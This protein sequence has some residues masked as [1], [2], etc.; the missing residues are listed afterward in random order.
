MNSMSIAVRISLAVAGLV[1]V[2]VAILLPVSLHKL[3][4]TIAE[5]EQRELYGHYHNFLA[6]VDQSADKAVSMARLVAGIPLVQETFARGDREGLK[7]LFAPGFATLK[8]ESG[9]R[10]FQFHVPPA[11]SFLRLHKLEK[12]GD[13]L[14]GFRHT[15]LQANE[16]KAPVQGLERGVAGLGIRGVVPVFHE[17]GHVGTV[18][19]GPGFDQTFVQAFKERFGVDVTV[20]TADKDTGA[21]ATLAS[22][23]NGALLGTED[24]R[25]AFDETVFR[26]LGDR[27]VLAAPLL[28]YSGQPAAMVEIVLD[29]T[30]YVAQYAETRN[31]L[32]GVGGI[33]LLAGLGLAWVLGTSLSKPVVAMTGAMH[34]LADGDLTVEVPSQDRKDE[35]GRM[36]EAMQVFKA[37][38][39]ENQA[40]REREEEQQRKAAEERKALMARLADEF[41]QSVAGI[42]EAL[43]SAATELQATAESMSSGAEETARQADAV[44]SAAEAASHNVETVATAAE[45][46]SASEDEISRQVAQST[47]IT[48]SAVDEARHSDQLVRGLAD[49]AQEIGEVVNLINDIAEQTNLLALNATI[50]AARAGDAG[51]GF[52]VVANEVKALATQTAKATDQISHQI[53]SVQSATREAVG[54]IEQITTTIGR[55]DEISTA[56]SA[57]VEQQSAATADIARNIHGAADGTQEVSSNIAGVSQAAGDTG[58]ASHQVLDTAHRLAREAES[59]RG[60]VDEFIHHVRAA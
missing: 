33:V 25:D 44:R 41:Q 10:Q 54:A 49:A 56:I 42:V 34:R 16:A 14:S 58:A 47:D 7:A 22:T 53:A 30:G 21:L 26:N 52:A 13:D 9:I 11:T 32:L 4:N 48:R 59:L 35:I 57:A 24:V 45:E 38:A 8:R 51:K 39:V 6:L 31:I 28:D 18:E 3:G 27:A 5:A 36:A 1:I 17:G 43:S 60:A 23:R 37:Q 29:A 19:F 12:F 40:L 2:V 20:L 55:I 50:E 46:L 15:V